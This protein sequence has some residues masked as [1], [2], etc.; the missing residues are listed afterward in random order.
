MAS[1]AT[2]KSSRFRDPPRFFLFELET[3]GKAAGI[4]FE[5]DEELALAAESADKIVVTVAD[6]SVAVGL[7]SA[8]TSSEISGILT[9]DLMPEGQQNLI[10]FIE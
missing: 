5:V 3:I 8:R 6:C 7:E 9:V 2:I 1:V 10:R 4:M